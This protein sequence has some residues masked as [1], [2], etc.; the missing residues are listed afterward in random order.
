MHNIIIPKEIKI[1]I[2]ENWVKL[3]NKKNIILK[4][5]IK[6]N[7][8]FMNKNKLY[9]LN[10]KNIKNYD[11]YLYYNFIN[12]LYGIKNGFIFKLRLIG[13][14]FKIT[15]NKQNIILKLGYSH[16]IK[17]T[18]SKKLNISQPKQRIPLYCITG[19][20]YNDITQLASNLKKLKKP[21]PYKGKGFCYYYEKIKRK[22]GK[23]NYV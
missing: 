5:K 9:F 22:E 20:N 4:K 11:R 13:I 16:L 12:S 15:I 14:G 23:K 10:N 3:Q 7:L 2:S 8:I 6:Y 19:S 21:E 18:I 1:N 17:Y